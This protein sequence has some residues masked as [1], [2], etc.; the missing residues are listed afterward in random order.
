MRLILPASPELTFATYSG[1]HGAL[2]ATILK[3]DFSRLAENASKLRCGSGMYGRET[4]VGYQ[5]SSVTGSVIPAC[6]SSAFALSGLYGY[7]STFGDQPKSCGG[8]NCVATC[9][10]PP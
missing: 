3:P 10:R 9:A 4:P 8:W 5:K 2:C 7:L 1:R 6:C